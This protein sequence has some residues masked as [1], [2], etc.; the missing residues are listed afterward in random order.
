RPEKFYD[1][2]VQVGIIRPGPIAGKMVP[3]YIRRRQGRERPDCLHPLLEPVLKRTLGVPLFQEQLLKMA[4]IV[5]GFTGGEA[6]ELRRAFGFKRSEARMEDVEVKLR[7]GMAA[8]GITGET[9]DRIVQ[10][11]TSF[12]LY[13]FPESHAASFAL[14]AYASAYLKCHYLAAFTAALLN[15]QPMGFYHP[16]TVVKDAQRHGLRILPADVTRSEWKC[17]IEAVKESGDTPGWFDGNHRLEQPIGVSPGFF[18]GSAVRLGLCYVKGLRQAAAEAIVAA[19]PFASIDDLARRVTG[20]RKD[21]LTRLAEVGALNTLERSHRRGALWMVAR[22]AR[23]TGPLLAE[24]P[25]S[26][27]TSP[28]RPMDPFERLDTDYTATGVNLGRHPM[29]YCRAEMNR[30]RVTPAARLARLRNGLLVRVA[31][32]VIVRQRP[33]TANGFLFLSLEDE[34]GIANIIVEPAIYDANRRLFR[35]HPFLLIEGVLQ[36]QDGVTSVRA[37]RI[38]PLSVLAATGVSHDFR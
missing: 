14:I 3:P 13:G 27:A 12:A 22:A 32:C 25:G 8:R 15:N 34:T 17:A 30:R 16:S 9:Q 35:D 28:L 21:E 26:D 36:N 19:R 23:P 2:V 18:H 33:G 6:E 37:G 38:E 7:R 11:I 1:I 29:A 20:L 31:G 10:S 24:A 4:M 5:A